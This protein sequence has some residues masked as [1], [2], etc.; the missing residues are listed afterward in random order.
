MRRRW[1]LTLAEAV[2]AVF[3]L[4]AGFAV[5]TQLF[6]RAL[7]YSTIITTRQ[8]AVA[9][10]N[11]RL[12]DIRA[13]SRAN[14][15]PAGT[16]AMTEWGP[17]AATPVQDPY[18]G[19]FTIATEFTQPEFYSPCSRFEGVV[20]AAGERL[21]FTSQRTQVTVTVSWSGGSVQLTTLVTSPTGSLSWRGPLLAWAAYWMLAAPPSPAGSSPLDPLPDAS[22]A[23]YSLN[24]APVSPTPG[25]AVTL[26]HDQTAH[27]DATLLATVGGVARPIPCQVRW[28]VLGPGS[29]TLKVLRGGN[30]VD[31]THRVVL[32]G[33]IVYADNLDTQLEACAVYRGRIF[34]ARTPMLTLS[35]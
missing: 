15:H 4:T 1:G 31:F 7:R 14:H 18:D 8:Q 29:G 23:V 26:S 32:N 20:G 10:A 19:L 17:F 21:R 24:V 33:L 35:P 11:R 28:S 12:E 9:I 34:R 2:V 6:H 27:Y 25:G 16:L 30:K 13:W 5:V 22:P 3:L